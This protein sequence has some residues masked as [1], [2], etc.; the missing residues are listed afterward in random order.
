MVHHDCLAVSI[1]LYFFRQKR[2]EKMKRFVL[3]IV[4]VFSYGMG[5]HA[6]PVDAYTVP[7]DLTNFFL[8]GDGAVASDG[9][10]ATLEVK[11]PDYGYTLLVNDPL[12]GDPGFGG[13]GDLF[14][15]SFGFDFFEATGN[16][17]EL[18]VRLL[19]GRTG[20]LIAD[21]GVGE[22]ST[23]IYAFDLADLLTGQT[24]LGLDFTLTEYQSDPGTG[25]FNTGSW[26]TITDLVLAVNETAPVPEPATL[27]LLGTGLVALG[28]GMRR[29]YR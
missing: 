27:M 22:T 18:Y 6:Q 14:S 24:L 5:F 8:E 15:L 2:E 12:G 3:F 20:G 1:G 16:D 23:G 17:T 26:V 29:K 21:F 19:D 9:S 13:P 28:A 7:I 11:D 25:S 10:S 4:L